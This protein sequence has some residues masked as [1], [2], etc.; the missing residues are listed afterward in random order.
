MRLDGRAGWLLAAPACVLTVVFFVAPLV[1]FLRFS[2]ERPSPTAFSIPVFTLENFTRFVSSGF[3]TGALLRTLLIALAS[4]LLALVLALPV[5]YLITRARGRVKAVLIIVTVFPLLVGNVVRSIGWVTVFGFSGVVN[6]VLT[7]VGLLDEPADLLH[8]SPTLTVAI[9]SVVLPLMVLTLQAS[10]ESVDPAT[11][12]AALDLGARPLRVFRQVVLPQIVPGIMAGTSLVFVLCINAYATPRL[13][14][15]AQVP[16]MAPTIYDTI[17]ADNNWPFG[18]SMAV[19]LLA[20]T[21]GV[22]VGYG[23]LL[24]RQLEGWRV[25]R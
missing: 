20:V 5:A 13:V 3:H 25:E 24:R 6:T 2:F 10:M 18:A 12:L 19:V 14:G 9:T 21:L 15:G 23:M 4:T 8:T 7:R 16:M 22:V 17:T 1:Y 11:E